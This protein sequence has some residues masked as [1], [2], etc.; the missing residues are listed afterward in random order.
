MKVLSFGR[1]LIPKLNEKV[2]VFRG[3]LRS[4]MSRLS[5]E[6]LVIFPILFLIILFVNIFTPKSNFQNIK[7][8]ILLKNNSV[9]NHNKLGQ[10]FFAANDYALAAKE[11][12]TESADF[13]N[14]LN[15]PDDI[16]K[17]ILYWQNLV[18]KIPSYRDGYLKLF[19]LN[20]KIYRDFDAQKF[21]KKA[22][23]VDPN[24][25]LP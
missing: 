24:F 15:Q 12:S 18:A 8:D 23:D 11:F 13:K 19:V 14:L 4:F 3:K 9:E 25:Y 21:F 17:Q 1:L 7:E 10:L 22:F 2:S 20:S 5:K 6:L 16:K